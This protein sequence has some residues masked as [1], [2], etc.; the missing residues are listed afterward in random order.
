EEA[1]AKKAERPNITSQE[2]PEGQMA[3]F[4]QGDQMGQRNQFNA[5]D[6]GDWRID[7]NG[8]PVRVDKSLEALNVREPLQRN[9]WGDE[10][11]PALGQE[12]SLTA[13]IDQMPAGI[14]NRDINNRFATGTTRGDALDLL[15]GEIK[16]EELRRASEAANRENGTYNPTDTRFQ[17]TAPLPTAPAG[18]WTP[19]AR[20]S[21]IKPFEAPVGP[22]RPLPE[23]PMVR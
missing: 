4:D 15:R 1:A 19:P 21:T 5:G 23:P 20:V 8:M 10:L 6:L 2:T 22:P 12:R 18:A 13:A 11:V 14:R 7:E 17:P 3:L 16:S 9:L